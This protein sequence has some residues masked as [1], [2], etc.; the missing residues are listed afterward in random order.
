MTK[1]GKVAKLNK[2][3]PGA[4]RRDPPGRRRRARRSPTATWSRSPP[5]AAGPCCPRV[6][7]DRVQPGSCF[8]P[9]HWNDLFGEYLSVNA[10]TNDA[11]DPI[12]FQPEFKVVRG[13]ADEG[14]RPGAA[15]PD[16]PSPDPA[17]A[18][19][20]PA[21]RRPPARLACSAWPTRRRPCRRART[22]LPGRVPRRRSAARRTAPA[23]RCCRAGAPFARSTRAVGRRPAGRACSPR[24]PPAAAAT[25]GAGAPAGA[26]HGGRCCGRRRPATPRSSPPTVA[27]RLD[28]SR[29]W[30]PRCVSMDDTRRRRPRR[31]APT[32]S[33]SPARSAT[34]TPPTTAPASGTR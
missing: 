32:C 29:A 11:V 12:S 13:L 2:L 16:G 4:V 21:D 15:A 23:C 18:P 17:E 25:G 28:R 33:S 8:A 5:G 27:D 14:R 1:T 6:V 26:A 24:A 10:V 9:F 20:A 22:P 19:A 3:N 31:R 34:A 30:Q 7:T